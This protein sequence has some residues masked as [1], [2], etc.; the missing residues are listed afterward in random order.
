[1]L[2]IHSL[3]IQNGHPWILTQITNERDGEYIK[4]TY[5]WEDYRKNLLRSMYTKVNNI[6]L[7]LD[8][9]V[10]VEWSKDRFYIFYSEFKDR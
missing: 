10:D 9:L 2:E 6:Y 8:E 4:T 3:I 7:T 1:M 5:L